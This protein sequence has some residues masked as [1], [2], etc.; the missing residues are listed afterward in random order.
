M[1]PLLH[2]PEIDSEDE[3]GIDQIIESLDGEDLKVGSEVRY[4]V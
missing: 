2:C 3:I 1:R 4:V